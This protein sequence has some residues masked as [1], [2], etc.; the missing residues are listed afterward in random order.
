MG[1]VPVVVSRAANMVPSYI[2]HH[3]GEMWG[4]TALW[5]S[6]ATCVT[7]GSPSTLGLY[8]CGR[9]G[10]PAE[11]TKV[12]PIGLRLYIKAWMRSTTRQ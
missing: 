1:T 6:A 11:C 7:R 8:P 4:Q 9:N 3:G 2:P 5:A 12:C 10:H